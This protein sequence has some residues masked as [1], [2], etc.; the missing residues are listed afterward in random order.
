MD[1]PKGK[2]PTETDDTDLGRVRQRLSESTSHGEERLDDSVQVP[3]SDEQMDSP[4][5]QERRVRGPRLSRERAGVGHVFQQGTHRVGQEGV[6]I[7]PLDG[8]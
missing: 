3:E 8:W 4:G 2:R 7:I 5:T 1:P 6:T